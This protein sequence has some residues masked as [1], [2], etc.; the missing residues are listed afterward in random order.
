M[1]VAGLVGLAPAA[2]AEPAGEIELA[3][4]AP[5]PRPGPDAGHCTADGVCIRA[6]S[7]VA[8]VCHVIEAAAQRNRLDPGFFARLIWKESLFDAAAVS[9]AGAQ[10]IAQF[11]PDTAKLRGLADPFNPAE[12]LA[13]SALYLADLARDFGNIGLAAVAYNGGEAR[14][15]AFVEA[16]AVLPSETR[17]YVQAITGYSADAWRDA[18]P[19]KVDLALP[20]EA[21]FQAACVA[22]AG[23]RRLREFPAGPPLKPWAVIVASNRDREAAE[24]QVGRLQNRHAEV[25]RGEPVSYTRA[26]RPGMPAR[27]YMA[28]VGRD[29]RADA[30]ALCARLKRSGGDCM[31]LRN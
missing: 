14:A 11:M 31:V 12:A 10:G 9:P 28:Q 30:D 22:Q 1:L 23:K 2:Q 17:A 24:R 13:A 3:A 15:A 6:A 18:P 5:P 4:L 25:L 16:K 19:E 7:Y 26:R 29:S 21:G 8:D 20:G 27:L